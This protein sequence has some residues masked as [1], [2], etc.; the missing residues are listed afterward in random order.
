MH[1]QIQKYIVP[2]YCKRQTHIAIFF[3][4]AV[5]KAAVPRVLPSIT[6]LLVLTEI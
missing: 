4:F 5:V 1:V 3:I 2:I 6:S